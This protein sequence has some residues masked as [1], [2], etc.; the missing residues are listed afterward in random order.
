MS[1]DCFSQP[2]CKDLHQAGFV[3]RSGYARDG[4]RRMGETGNREQQD[5]RGASAS[6]SDAC[7]CHRMEVKVGHYDQAFVS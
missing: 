7:A 6:C 4:D 2:F 3:P 5:V 1:V